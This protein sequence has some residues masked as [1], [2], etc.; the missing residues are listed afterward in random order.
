[1]AINQHFITAFLDLNLKGDESKR[2]YLHVTPAESN[3]GKWPLPPGES[4]GDK[5]SDGT[6]YWKGFQRR[7][8]LGASMTCTAA[9]Q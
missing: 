8:A 6:G 4:A 1:M 7:W 5:V 3:D 9:M 2:S